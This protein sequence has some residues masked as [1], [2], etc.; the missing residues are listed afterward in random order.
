MRA[1]WN[2]EHRF[3]TACNPRRE[4]TDLS[5]FSVDTEP[6]GGTAGPCTQPACVSARK[7]W[8]KV[9]GSDGVSGPHGY[10]LSRVRGWRLP[11]N[12]IVVGRCG[13]CAFCRLQRRRRLSRSE[14]FRLPRRPCYGNPFTVAGALESGFAT[15]I[16]DAQKLCADAFDSW[17]DGHSTWAFADGEQRREWL[18]GHLHELRGHNLACWCGVDRPCHRNTLL[19]VSNA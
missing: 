5:L 15:T 10:Q 14:L 9:H 6:S 4:Y 11:A 1:H 12:T 2:D 17:L 7:A 19:R 13:Q 16:D 8:K 18:L 3:H